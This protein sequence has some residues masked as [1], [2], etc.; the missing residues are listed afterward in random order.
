MRPD[1]L[2]EDIDPPRRLGGL[3]TG[4]WLGSRPVLML[5]WTVFEVEGGPVPTGLHNFKGGT[6]ADLAGG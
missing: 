3:W 6:S 4:R 5:S 2:S 1:P